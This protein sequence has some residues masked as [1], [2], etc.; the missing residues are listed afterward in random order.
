MADAVIVNPIPR[1]R[2]RGRDRGRNNGLD[3][4]ADTVEPE[5]IRKIEARTILFEITA[6]PPL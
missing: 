5:K 3:V 4:V 2:I 6:R 1:L